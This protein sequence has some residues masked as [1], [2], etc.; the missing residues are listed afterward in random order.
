MH[1][2][3]SPIHIYIYKFG[4]DIVRVQITFSYSVCACRVQ[5]PRAHRKTFR[6]QYVKAMYVV[7]I[8]I[9]ST[10]IHQLHP[11]S[12]HRPYRNPTIDYYYLLNHNYAVFLSNPL[13]TLPYTQ[14]QRS[15]R[16]LEVFS[17]LL[18]LIFLLPFNGGVNIFT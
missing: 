3:P 4:G 6:R 13:G 16:F 1:F 18:Y 10:C 17:F 11:F 14:I 2:T 8:V 9:T 12:H 15:K 5:L 7:H